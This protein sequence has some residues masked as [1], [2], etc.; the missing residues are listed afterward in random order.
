MMYID[1]AIILFVLFI[2]I[3]LMTFFIIYEEIYYE[4]DRFLRIKRKINKHIN[5][6]NELN[7]HIEKLKDT[8]VNFKQ[9]DYGYAV[10]VDNS[11]YNYQRKE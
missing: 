8:Y 4:S 11:I 7:E 3:F 10:S 2:P 9:T 6:C 1:D 5:E